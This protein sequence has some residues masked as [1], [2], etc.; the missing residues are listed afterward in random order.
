MNLETFIH[1]IRRTLWL[2]LFWEQL[3][4]GLRL[5]LGCL[6]LCGMVHVWLDPLPLAAVLAAAGI[7]LVY[8]WYSAFSQRPGLIAA[9]NYADRYLAAKSLLLTAVELQSGAQTVNSRYA[10]LILR[11]AEQMLGV[12]QK[13]LALRPLRPVNTFSWLS[14]TLGMLGI[15]LILQPGKTQ[16]TFNQAEEAPATVQVQETMTTSPLLTAIKQQNAA[17]N[18]ERRAP[19]KL[20]AEDNPS[21]AQAEILQPMPKDAKNTGGEQALL[22][23]DAGESAHSRKGRKASA[24]V[25]TSNQQAAPILQTC[26]WPL[27][28]R[29][30][31]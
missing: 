7:P 18:A 23:P 6:L 29:K 12:W 25:P 8:A 10:D 11:Q 9:A 19:A 21:P 26:G 13:Q 17:A 31:A 27:S 5:G 2:N 16:Q 15:F 1:S 22:P 28:Y 24:T 14:T 4:S 30:R 20:L 3:Q